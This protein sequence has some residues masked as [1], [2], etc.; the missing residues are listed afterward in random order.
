MLHSHAWSI[1]TIMESIDIEHFH[2]YRKF[3]LILESA[4]L[5]NLTKIKLLSLFQKLKS[6]SLLFKTIPFGMTEN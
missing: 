1:A 3:Y 5:E 2:H 4:D 6:L